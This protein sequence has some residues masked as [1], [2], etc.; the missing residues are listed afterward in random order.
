M[1]KI[2][3]IT[4]GIASGKST[5]TA[6]LRQLGYQVIDADQ[7]VHDLQAK[8]GKLYQAL[9]EWLGQDIL[10][11]EDHLNRPALAQI[12]FASK[13]NLDRSADLQNGIIRAELA[14][15]RDQLAQTE[16]MFFMDI[17]LL[18]EV[19]YVDWFDEIWLV[20]LDEENQLQRLKERNGYSDQEAKKRLDSQMSLAQKRPFAHRVID[21]SGSKEETFAQIRQALE[22]IS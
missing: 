1:T 7:V 19:D 22:G 11:Q 17:P 13:E 16:P 3:G 5:V 18:I 9:V 12:I 8:G 10:D 14:K 2:I 4:G 21:N 6:Y 15:K 20:D